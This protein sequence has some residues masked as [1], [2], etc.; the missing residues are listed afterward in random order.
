LFHERD[1]TTGFIFRGVWGLCI[2]E[3]S[4]WLFFIVDPER[5]VTLPLGEEKEIIPPRAGE[6][7]S[8]LGPTAAAT[9]L[10]S[11]P[12]NLLLSLFPVAQEVF[13]TLLR[14]GLAIGG[15]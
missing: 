3:R 1:Y 13:V 4:F 12:E 14:L 9:N 6:N 10:S 8:S 11:G 5:F 15:E 7:S 2:S